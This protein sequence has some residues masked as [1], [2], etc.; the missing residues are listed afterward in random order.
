MLAGSGRLSTASYLPAACFT[1]PPLSAPAFLP[2]ASTSFGALQAAVYLSASTSDHPGSFRRRLLHR[3]ADLPRHIRRCT[4]SVLPLSTS[5]VRA[6]ASTSRLRSAGRLSAI[7]FVAFCSR[8]HVLQTAA[9]EI[10]A[11][12]RQLRS[13]PLQRVVQ[14]RCKRSILSGIRPESRLPTGSPAEAGFPR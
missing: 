10:F 4:G 13:W 3:A 11:L 8:H 2:D 7:C 9:R 1:A 5:C 6:C 14:D 12:H